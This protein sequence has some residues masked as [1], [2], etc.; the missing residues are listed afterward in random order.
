MGWDASAPSPSPCAH[1]SSLRTTAMRH[2]KTWCASSELVA[3]AQAC[4]RCALRFAGVRT[5]VY[6]IPPPDP[7]SLRAALAAA[8]S[9]QR[10]HEN[11]HAAAAQPSTKMTR[12]EE[13]AGNAGY[14]NQASRPEKDISGNGSLADLPA[15][16]PE[17]AAAGPASA[18]PS[19]IDAAHRPSAT[20]VPAAGEADVNGDIPS[21]DAGVSAAADAAHADDT[22]QQDCAAVTRICP[23]CL[24]IL[25][26]PD[27]PQALPV[28]T[29]KIA[30]PAMDASG[31]DWQI[32]PTGDVAAIAAAARYERFTNRSPL[33]MPGACAAHPRGKNAVCCSGAK[34]T[35]ASS[36]S[37]A[38]GEA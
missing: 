26:V 22:R 20:A 21:A 27:S 37:S 2:L 17:V 36:M 31:G 24:G 3:S 5:A 15:Q 8:C 14:N 35:Q 13:S 12:P 33:G 29:A 23:L 10:S 7:E 25:Q 6:A 4:A 16:P 9:T 18:E 1:P 11:T 32:L 34:A 38:P 30:L 28:G 19:A